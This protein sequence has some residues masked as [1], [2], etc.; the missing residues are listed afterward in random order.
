M[1]N[2]NQDRHKKRATIASA[3]EHSLWT[4]L[5]Q[6]VGDNERSE[7]TRQLW[8]AFLKRPGARMPKRSDYEQLR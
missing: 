8:A 2:R 5:G 6:V 4:E 7:V 3:D 1:G